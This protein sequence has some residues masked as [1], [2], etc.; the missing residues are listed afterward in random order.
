MRSDTGVWRVVASRAS[1]RKKIPSSPWPEPLGFPLTEYP[2]NMHPKT[3]HKL[4]CLGFP[5]PPNS[6]QS[7]AARY[8]RSPMYARRSQIARDIQ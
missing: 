5:T 3:K 8:E 4:R 1:V 7:S 6:R 2:H